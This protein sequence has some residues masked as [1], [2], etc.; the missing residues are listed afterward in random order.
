MILILWL[1]VGLFQNK[2]MLM[3]KIEDKDLVKGFK[4]TLCSIPCTIESAS[5]ASEYVRY[6]EDNHTGSAMIR[7]SILLSKLNKV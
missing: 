3:L 4:F 7:R 2:L 1:D 5:P 6:I